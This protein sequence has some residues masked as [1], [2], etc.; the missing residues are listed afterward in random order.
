MGRRNQLAAASQAFNPASIGSLHLWLDGADTSSQT[1][2][3]G[4]ISDWRDKSGNDRHVTQASAANRPTQSSLN[5]LPAVRFTASSSQTM[6]R[7]GEF[8]PGDPSF[9]T[10]VVFRKLSVQTVT[11]FGW[12][13]Q[14]TGAHFL[15]FPQ[16]LG[17]SASAYSFG[18]TTTYNFVLNNADPDSFH[19]L[20]KTWFDCFVKPSGPVTGASAFR[21]GQYFP[22]ASASSASPNISGPL[23]I[24]QTPGAAAQVFDG[25][26]G[27]ILVYSKALTPDER[28]QVEQYISK[29]WQ[30]TLANYKLATSVAAQ[31][32][33]S[34]LDVPNCA[35]WL[36]GADASTMYTSAIG[37]VSPVSA[38][39][40]I[41]GCVGWWDASDSGSIT[42]SGG[43]VSQWSDKSGN[44]KHATAS[45]SSRPTYTGSQNG[46][47]VIAFD[48]VANRMNTTLVDSSTQT[49][50]FVAKA[51]PAGAPGI[52]RVVAYEAERSFFASSGWNWFSPPSGTGVSPTAYNVAS[53]VI[54]SDSSMTIYGNGVAA[55]ATFDPFNARTN[56]FTLGGESASS[57][58][59]FF[60]GEIAEVIVF[61]SALSD[62]N[63]ARVEK[64]LANKWGVPG[65]HSV[66]GQTGDP[67]RYW[68]DK[69]GGD[70]H[71]TSPSLPPRLDALAVNGRP[72]VTFSN[73]NM[74]CTGRSD[75]IT[76]ETVFLVASVANTVN[77]SRFFTQSPA[78]GADSSVAGH[79]IPLLRS[80][81]TANISSFADSGNRAT[82][83]LSLGSPT[84]M[85]STHTGSSI[86]N[87]ANEIAS[88]PYSHSLSQTI[89][90]YGVFEDLVGGSAFTNGRVM[91]VIVYHRAVSA[92]ERARVVR[93]L[94]NK[95]GTGLIPPLAS[96]PDAQDWVNRVYLNGGTCSQNTAD[97]VSSFC[98]DIDAAGLRSKLYRVNLFCGNE[99]TACR[100]PL[101]RGPS[102]SERHGFDLDVLTVG[103]GGSAGTVF[104]NADYVEYGINGGLAGRLQAANNAHAGPGLRTGV[105][106]A[107]IPAFYGPKRPNGNSFN[108]SSL[109]LATYCRGLRPQSLSTGFFIGAYGGIG[110]TFE[111]RHGMAFFV[112]QA[113][114]GIGPFAANVTGSYDG[115]NRGFY[116]STVAPT[117]SLSANEYV[118]QYVLYAGGSQYASS[119][120]LFGPFL[121]PNIDFSV[122]GECRATIAYNQNDNSLGRAEQTLQGYSIGLGLNAT[123]AQAYSQIMNRF[124][125]RLGR[126]VRTIYDAATFASVTNPDA[127]AWVQAVY[128]S[129]G[130]VSVATATAVNTF[131]NAIDSAG[132]RDRFYRLNLFCGDN[133]QACMV[134]IYRGPTLGGTQ[135]GH[136]IDANVNFVSGDYVER[137]SSAGLTGNGTNKWL[138]TGVAANLFSI[139][140]SHLGYGLRAAFSADASYPSAIGAQDAPTNPNRYWL[141]Q[142]RR[143]NA[144]PIA[145]CG[146]YSSGHLFGPT[147]NGTNR[148]PSN[149]VASYPR[150]FENATQVGATATG[151]ANFTTSN[152]IAVFGAS[153]SATTILTT[154]GQVANARLDWYSVGLGMSSSQVAAFNSCLS[155][156]QA[157]LSRT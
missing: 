31:A 151:Y 49:I 74:R 123:E 33:A 84:I 140:N 115:V 90:N 27:E 51:S 156:F 30:I 60:Q 39:T 14:N 65:V 118:N 21:S 106:P 133:L 7:A 102:V 44:G 17:G 110:P 10:F 75:A 120:S 26:I 97:A 114:W 92:S 69:S 127:A 78:S 108:Y 13:T 93:Y 68:R 100:T 42:Q 142:Y 134:P 5:G 105:V 67:V 143:A 72:C 152:P 55:S 48:G 99:I 149:I 96:H 82:V 57:A 43:L 132:L 16:Q 3:S 154:F 46:R 38:P 63:R 4:G 56:T 12:G 22:P 125:N 91:E 131:C 77:N 64:Y 104:A 15:L 45:G 34:P 71:F 86:T 9:T 37:P 148:T 128:A 141:I 113:A 85:T 2:I 52:R 20:N 112:N 130:S 87:T 121:H 146:E 98:R 94:Q 54:A 41:S 83:A 107:L 144:D 6:S 35:I 137:G 18:G 101:Y 157:S 36:D 129:G 61:N 29:K 124:Q 88:S 89:A 66:V 25:L 40:D 111:A 103:S 81:T 47:S 109:H 53:G 138:N 116:I 139:N 24:G 117:G 28:R 147:S 119:Q 76:Q 136:L 126:G 95:W 8:L 50:L 79:W 23:V 62:V 1:V 150:Y 32:V 58:F 73:S 19:P 145:S 70:R 122:Y 135:Y 155:T 11:P 153:S 80:G 59:N